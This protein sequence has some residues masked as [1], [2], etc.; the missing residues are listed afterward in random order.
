MLAAASV[1][2]AAA[3]SINLQI[4]DS[5]DNS[6]RYLVYAV[7]VFVCLLPV[8]DLCA[9]TAWKYFEGTGLV[10]AMED[11]PHIVIPKAVAAAEQEILPFP[12]KAGGT[13]QRTL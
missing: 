6:L 13:E 9:A 3:R 11:Q 10:P 4:L 8:L 12:M 5:L 1:T 7:L 2:G